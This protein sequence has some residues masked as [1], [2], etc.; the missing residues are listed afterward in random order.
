MGADLR[1]ADYVSAEPDRIVATLLEWLPDGRYHA[2]N[3]RMLMSQFWKGLLAAGELLF[4]LGQ[5][6]G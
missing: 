1:L 6:S 3:E 2:P 4:E 5:L